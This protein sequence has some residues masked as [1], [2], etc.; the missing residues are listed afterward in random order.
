MS[1]AAEHEYIQY[2][3][4]TL[5]DELVRFLDH[6]CSANRAAEAA[7]KRK[8]PVCIW[9]EHGIG[10]TQIV[11]SFAR[12]R[13]YEFVYVAPAQFEEMG[14]LVGMP[15]AAADRTVFLPPDW[16]PTNDGPG[17][18]LLDD[19]NRADDRILRGIM[20]LLQNYELVSWKLPRGWDIVLTANPDGGDYSVT[21]MDDAMITRMMHVTLEF[22]VKSWARW[23]EIDGIDE[24]GINF[25]LTYPE[26]VVGRRTTPRTLVQF[27]DAIKS[28]DDL[29]KNIGMVQL[30][31]D[32]VLDVETSAAFL[33][34]VRSKLSK[35]ITPEEILYSKNFQKE[36]H[37]Y[38]NKIL[39]GDIVRVDLLATLCTRVINY[40]SNTKKKPGPGVMSNLAAFL[41]L[42]FMPAD[43]RLTTAQE[44]V[45]SDNPHLKTLMASPEI[46]RLLLT[47]M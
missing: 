30:L 19:V 3:T 14:D 42:D 12:E 1:A 17:I 43:L 18:L 24:R 32:G 46:G 9:G 8:T 15:R 10:K 27:F 33:G 2:G 28:I 5:A 7:K 25:V 38:L 13:G 16:V 22:D 37:T 47:Q 4:K 29:E 20:Q 11:E 26:I 21:S 6:M 35:L 40:L 41:M 44:I 23:A 45:S 34:F 36:V 31:A 39:A